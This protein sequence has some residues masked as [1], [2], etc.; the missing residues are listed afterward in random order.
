[1]PI[2]AP[3]GPTMCRD[4]SLIYLGVRMYGEDREIPKDGGGVAFCRS[5]DGGYHWEVCSEIREPAWL[6][7]GAWLDE[8]HVLELPDGRLMAAFRVEGPFTLAA[9]FSRDGGYTWGEVE[10]LGVCGSPPHLML[11]SSGALICTYARRDEVCAQCAIVSHD[12]GTS[13]ETGY[14]IDDRSSTWDLGYP[15][16][17]ELDDGSL[18]TVYYQKYGEDPNCSILY[19]RWRLQNGEES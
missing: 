4:G 7:D 19:T 3:H 16:T 9:A 17:V 12:L 8:P 10:D 1:I 14:M 13:W 2:S 18:M 5:V 15:S 6:P 11:H